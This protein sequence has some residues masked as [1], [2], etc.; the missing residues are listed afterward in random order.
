MQTR[1]DQAAQDKVFELIKDIRV[2]QFVTVDRAGKLRARPMVAQQ[3]RFDG[4]LWFFTPAGSGKIDEIEHHREV[5]L[6][7]S[8]PGSQSYVS[9]V[10]TADVQRDPAKVKELWSEPMRVWFPN[11]PADPDIA[12][13]RV[14]VREA[15]Y[16]DAPSS[17]FV[18]AY[19]YL[20][21]VTTGQRPN[22]GETA[23]VE[24]DDGKPH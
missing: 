19:G 3:E 13:L 21:A 8:D 5:L 22:P 23:H 20:K 15:D 18:H 24:F 10:G 4:V 14:E 2:A 16:W 17:T 12:L 7:Y 11:G 1:T 9:V 6:T